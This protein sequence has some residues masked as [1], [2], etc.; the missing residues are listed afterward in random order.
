MIRFRLIHRLLHGCVCVIEYGNLLSNFWQEFFLYSI[1]FSSVEESTRTGKFVL[2]H[3]MKSRAQKDRS[4][5]DTK[6]ESE[7]KR[8]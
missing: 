6:N 1:T 2:F 4:L 7:E 3:G 8:I 5:S